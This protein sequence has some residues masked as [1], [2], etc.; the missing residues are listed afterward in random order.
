MHQAFFQG[1]TGGQSGQGDKRNTLTE[2][3]KKPLDTGLF[4]Q[5]GILKP[6]SRRAHP[7]QRLGGNRKKRRT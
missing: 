6:G 3:E 7:E 5:K 1:S 4:K 2:K